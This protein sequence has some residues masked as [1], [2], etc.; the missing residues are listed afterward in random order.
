MMRW[1]ST[2][3]AL[4]ATIGCSG[5]PSEIVSRPSSPE[6]FVGAWRSVT[7]SLE[8]I[9]LSVHSTSSEMGVL[10][11]QLTLSGVAWEGGGRIDG[12][13]LVIPSVMGSTRMS[14]GV[15]VARARDARTLQVQVRP[16]GAES[17]DLTLVR[18]D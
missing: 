3:A 5:G 9:R 1:I 12:D 13:S 18:E 11:A 8:F 4:C 17:F 16:A 14:S 10:G 6:E 15:I 7:P 2:A